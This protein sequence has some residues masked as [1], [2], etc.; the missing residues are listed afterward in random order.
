M[1]CKSGKLVTLVSY[2][3]FYCVKQS[4]STHAIKAYG[5][6]RLQP[7]SFLISALDGGECSV[8]C[9]DCFIPRDRTPQ[10]LLNRRLS[11]HQSQYGYFYRREK[12]LAPSGIQNP[13]C[14]T[15]NLSLFQLYYPG[16][17]SKLYCRIN[18]IKCKRLLLIKKCKT[19]YRNNPPTIQIQK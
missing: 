5:G 12:S 6:V 4:F 16:T 18:T 2:S 9:P 11:G 10:H 8:S 13:D 17:H 7:L 15:H 14:Q 19:V 3:I 1:K